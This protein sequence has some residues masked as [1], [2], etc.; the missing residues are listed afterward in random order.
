[1]S[2]IFLLMPAKQRL[3]NEPTDGVDCLLT[4]K[5]VKLILKVSLATIYNMAERGQLPAVAWDS[6][7]SGKRSS[8]VIR[9]KRQDIF[10]FIECNYRK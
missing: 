2:K 3:N 4:A 9:F 10:D 1:M 6:P 8:K 5:E 7:G